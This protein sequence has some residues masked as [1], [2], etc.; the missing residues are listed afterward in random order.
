MGLSKLFYSKSTCPQ[1]IKRIIE[2]W[3]GLGWLEGTFKDHGQRHLSLDQVTQSPV[4]HSASDDGIHSSSGQPVLVS[5]H[6]FVSFAIN[7]TTRKSKKLSE[8]APGDLSPTFFF[9]WFRLL[10]RNT[11]TSSSQQR[12]RGCG[13]TWRTRTPGMSSLTPVQQT[14]KLSKPMRMWP[15]GSASPNWPQQWLG[16][17]RRFLFYRLFSLLP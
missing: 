5:D 2:L 4:Q 15:S 1:E 6:T 16:I 8:M 10:Q 17:P 12:W 9:L 11:A 13:G 14:K 7:Y 3:N